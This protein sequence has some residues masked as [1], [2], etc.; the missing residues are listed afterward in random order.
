MKHRKLIRLAVFIVCIIIICLSIHLYK[1]G[2]IHIN[3][4]NPDKYPVVGVD[5][6]NHQGEIDWNVLTEQE[7][8]FAFIKATEGSTFVDPYF[9]SNWDSAVATGIRVGAYHFFSFESSGENQAKSFCKNVPQLE[10]MLPPVVDVEYYGEFKS[11]KD[12][13]IPKIKEE[14]R[15]FI[16]ILE[17]EY[18]MKPIIYCGLLYD[19]I[20]KGDFTDYDLWYPS[21]YLPLIK[22]KENLAFWQ[23]SNNHIL[24]GY[25]GTQKFIDMNV[26]IGSEEEFAK[27]PTE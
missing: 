21:V 15:T 1:Q 7:I 8:D 25:T 12:L 24:N 5:V 13:D 23:Y 27:Y 22:N 26:Y 17:K 9:K 4:P 16:N 19:S 2:I 10:N 18:G 14:L 3:N 20:I 11:K 6:S